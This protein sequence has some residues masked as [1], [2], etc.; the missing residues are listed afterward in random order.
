L[1][2]VE[3]R[4]TVANVAGSNASIHPPRRLVSSTESAADATAEIKS[5]SV[6]A[7]WTARIF[8]LLVS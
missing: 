6:T 5:A 7:S 8:A 3:V 2:G 4:K 1:E